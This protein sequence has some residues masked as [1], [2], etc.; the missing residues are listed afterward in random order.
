LAEAKAGVAGNIS[1]IKTA[2]GFPSGSRFSSVPHSLGI[3]AWN[4][5]AVYFVGFPL[6]K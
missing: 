6:Q 4:V 3:L 2:I 5:G 1:L